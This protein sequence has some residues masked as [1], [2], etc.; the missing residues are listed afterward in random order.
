MTI[1]VE[2][3]PSATPEVRRLVDELNGVLAAV[4]TEDQ[5]H[6]LG[7]EQLFQPSIRFFIARVGDVAAGCGGVEVAD[8]HAEVKRMYT[9]T[10]LR[11]QG[12]AWAVLR[13]LEAEARAAGATLLRL[14]TGTLQSEAIGL[15]ERA[16]FRRCAPFGRYAEMPAPSIEFSLFFEKPL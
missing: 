7:L 11:R 12:V 6:G 13:R 10:G 14:E 1:T 8:G 16:G 4:Y 3:V 15:Y 5:R 2:R 9:R